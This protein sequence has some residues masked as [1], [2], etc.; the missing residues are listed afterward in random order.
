MEP[1]HADHPEYDG[2]DDPREIADNLSPAAR[3]TLISEAVTEYRNADDWQRRRQV[4]LRRLDW[5]E[6]IWFGQ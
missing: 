2:P 5:A 4:F 3:Q 6:G 1:W